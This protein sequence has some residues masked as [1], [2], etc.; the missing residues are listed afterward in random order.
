MS[1]AVTDRPSVD[2]P[3]RHATGSVTSR[4]GT[5]IGFRRFGEGRL[6]W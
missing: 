2:A 4:D 3:E 6:S 5:T 1:T